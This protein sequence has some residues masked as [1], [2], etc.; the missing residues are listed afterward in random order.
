MITILRPPMK[1]FVAHCSYCECDFDYDLSDVEQSYVRCP[2]CFRPVEH[3]G[4]TK[5]PTPNDELIVTLPKGTTEPCYECAWTSVILNNKNVGISGL[6]PCTWCTKNNKVSNIA[7]KGPS[8]NDLLNDALPV[9]TVLSGSKT[10]NCGPNA[11]C[12]KCSGSGSSYTIATSS[13]SESE[14][15]AHVQCLCEGDVWK[16]VQTCC[17]GSCDGSCCENSASTESKPKC[18]CKHTKDN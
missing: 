15:T 14:Q 4:N 16:T 11:V 2:A 7:V 6:D 13:S 5:L 3:V 12:S 17:S 18:T 9:S 10:C 1:K 8:L